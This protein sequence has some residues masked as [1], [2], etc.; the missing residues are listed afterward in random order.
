MK[1]LLE[2]TGVLV[3][4][5]LID[6]IIENIIIYSN[7]GV[8]L[9]ERVNLFLIEI[10]FGKTSMDNLLNSDEGELHWVDLSDILNFEMLLTVTQMLS[11]I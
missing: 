7:K 11:I 5:E 3:K 2:L 10:Y 8:I 4:E 6:F 9:Q 1:I